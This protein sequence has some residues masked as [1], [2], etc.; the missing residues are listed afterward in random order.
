MDASVFCMDDW[1]CKNMGCS[2]AAVQLAFDI[3]ALAIQKRPDLLSTI[4]TQLEQQFA[5]CL[6]GEANGDTI[7]RMLLGKTKKKNCRNQ[8]LSLPEK[9]MKL[10]RTCVANRL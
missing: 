8:I 5:F 9:K 1:Y 4:D 6:S 2:T 10:L 7:C 3:F